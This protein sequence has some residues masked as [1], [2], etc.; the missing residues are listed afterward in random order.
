VCERWLDAILRDYGPVTAARWRKEQDPFANP[1]GHALSTGLPELLDA[2]ARGQGYGERALA[3]L[4]E[5]VR[6]RSVQDFTPSRAVGF[7]CL[8][9]R[10]VRD[11]LAAAPA[12]GGLE[13]ELT[14]LDRRIEQ[15]ALLAFDTYV[16][17]REELFRI[18]QEELRRSV[19]SILRR[20]HGGAVPDA[21]SEDLVRLSPTSG[22]ARR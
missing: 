6:V 14:E 8:L 17:L 12:G 7:V 10:A 21:A 20:W 9:R 11:E 5:I 2:I 22:G 18:R 3:A 4:Q 1:V 16:G 15:L 19:G 13:A